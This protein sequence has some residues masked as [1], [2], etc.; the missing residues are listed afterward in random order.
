MMESERENGLEAKL[1][2]SSVTNNPDQRRDPGGFLA[3]ERHDQIRSV[4][5]LIL[6]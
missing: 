1:E 2:R 4:L 5:K 3:G 6:C